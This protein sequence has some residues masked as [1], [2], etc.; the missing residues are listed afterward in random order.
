MSKIKNCGLDQYG[1]VWSLNGIDSE[2]VFLHF[3]SHILVC[4]THCDG[5]HLH[6]AT[7]FAITADSGW[8]SDVRI[9]LGIIALQRSVS[10]TEMCIVWQDQ[11][12]QCWPVYQ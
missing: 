5:L 3:P 4:D 2:T 10:Q 9:H 1:K 12:H 8:H 11:Q 7:S 6:E